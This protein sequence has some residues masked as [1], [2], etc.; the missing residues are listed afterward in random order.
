MPFAWHE[1]VELAAYLVGQS[2]ERISEEAFQRTA[3]SRAYFAA[4]CHA[5]DYASRQL[6]FR[7]EGNVNDHKSLREHLRQW[8]EPWKEVAEILDELR[9]WRND[10]DYTP[11]ITSWL[12]LRAVTAIEFARN[13]IDVCQ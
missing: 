6:G 4:F 12:P 10:A 9:Q 2:T 5:R 13:V 7:R 11:N 1:F 3:V 8:G